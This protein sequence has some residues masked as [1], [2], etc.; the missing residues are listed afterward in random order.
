MHDLREV[1]KADPTCRSLPR[2]W[3]DAR[4]VEARL[5]DKGWTRGWLMG[6]RQNARTGDERTMITSIMPRYGIGH[7]IFLFLPVQEPHLSAAL[8]A[9]LNNLPLDFVFRQ[10]LGGINLSFYYVN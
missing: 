1:E 7:S 4:E 9:S 6:W 10:K 2:Y 3:V 5:A 8:I